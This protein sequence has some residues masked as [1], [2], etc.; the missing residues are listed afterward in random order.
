MIY[1]DE[2]V[3]FCEKPPPENS[4]YGFFA[5]ERGRLFPNGL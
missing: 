1:F 4:I 3:R 2:V 5:R